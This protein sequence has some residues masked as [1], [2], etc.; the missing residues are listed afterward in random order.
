MV[1]LELWHRLR[2]QSLLISK[3]FS[4]GVRRRT[5][6]VYTNYQRETSTPVGQA[7]VYSIDTPDGKTE[8]SILA[9]FF[10]PVFTSLWESLLHHHIGLW[11]DAALSCVMKLCHHS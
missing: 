7:K 2:L 5:L 1:D 6:V 4:F 8:E 9:A 11:N 10:H 3:I